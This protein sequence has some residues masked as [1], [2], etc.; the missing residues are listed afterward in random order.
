MKLL[1][2]VSSIGKF[3]FPH[4]ETFQNNSEQIAAQFINALF[5]E[6]CAHCHKYIKNPGV[7]DSHTNIQKGNLTHVLCLPF[8]KFAKVM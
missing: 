7:M 5:K 8:G 3:V 2:R 4:K 6:F 1:S